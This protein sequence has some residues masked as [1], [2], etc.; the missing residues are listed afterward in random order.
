M[1][2]NFVSWE[3]IKNKMALHSWKWEHVK[4]QGVLRSNSM[5]KVLLKY[6]FSW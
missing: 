5:S 2:D 4:L 1:C 3:A 6:I